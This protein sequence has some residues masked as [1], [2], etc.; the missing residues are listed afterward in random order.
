MHDAEG[1]SAEFFKA[2]LEGKKLER[3]MWVWVDN[4][5]MVLKET[6]F[7]FALNSSTITRV[8]KKNF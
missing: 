3:N 7:D 8:Q 5:K 1:K 2:T 4:I 6:D